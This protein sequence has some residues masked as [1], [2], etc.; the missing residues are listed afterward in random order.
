MTVLSRRCRASMGLAAG[1]LLLAGTTACG[2][3]NTASDP[4]PTP[5]AASSPDT[6]ASPAASDPAAPPTPGATASDTDPGDGAAPA[7]ITIDSPESGKQ[8]SST[9]SVSGT[10]NSPEA[11]VPWQID[12]PTDGV[13][14]SGFATADGWLDKAYPWS[15]SI[16]VGA[17][18][19]GTY[20]FTARVDDDSKKEGTPPPSA[21][22]TFIKK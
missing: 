6:T 20:T 10:A 15:T 22:I 11:N 5:A 18:Q 9:L 14:V 13:L 4:D 1:A 3:T 7:S 8:V 21:T 17:L 19:P 2:S 12:S 16:D